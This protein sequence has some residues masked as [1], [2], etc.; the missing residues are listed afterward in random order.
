MTWYEV[1]TGNRNKATICGPCWTCLNVR[2]VILHIKFEE[3]LINS[4]LSFLETQ[5]TFS[6]KISLF[7]KIDAFFYSAHQSFWFNLTFT[8]R[9]MK[10][11][12]GILQLKYISFR[13]M[14][15]RVHV[16]N[17]WPAYLTNLTSRLDMLKSALL[18]LQSG[19][20]YKVTPCRHCWSGLN[21]RLDI[22]RIKFTKVHKN[23]SMSLN[24]AYSN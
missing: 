17:P 4:C 11:T 9:R 12:V 23:I 20:R 3:M 2:P 14:C 16:W 19:S 8:R 6:S 7:A 10:A 13:H 15:T 24:E 1:Q 21:A 22:L 18:R 5:F